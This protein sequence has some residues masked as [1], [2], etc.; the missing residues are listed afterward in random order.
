M[1]P[2]YDIG[3]KNIKEAIPPPPPIGEI[4]DRF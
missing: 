4:L 1:K 2:L 3:S